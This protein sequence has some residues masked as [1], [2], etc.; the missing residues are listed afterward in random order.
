MGHGPMWTTWFSFPVCPPHISPYPPPFTLRSAL[1]ESYQRHFPEE[2][3]GQSTHCGGK[4]DICALLQIPE[5]GEPDSLLLYY[6]HD[7]QGGPLLHACTY[8]RL[9]TYHYTHAYG[10]RSGVP[11]CRRGRLGSRPR[12]LLTG[13]L[14]VNLSTLAQP[15]VSITSRFHWLAAPVPALGPNPTTRNG[16]RPARKQALGQPL[17]LLAH[18]FPPPPVP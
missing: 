17:G 18:P 5:R 14:S 7:C 11:P 8:T 3:R 16:R 15:A 9:H 10:R 4:A 12:R 6:V 1:D 13:H 2:S